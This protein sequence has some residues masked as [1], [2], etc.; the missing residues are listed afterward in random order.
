MV[1]MS[2]QSHDPS[3]EFSTTRQRL[4]ELIERESELDESERLPGL[5]AIASGLEQLVEAI[6]EEIVPVVELLQI[7]ERVTQ[8]PKNETV[9]KPPYSR[10]APRHPLGDPQGKMLHKTRQATR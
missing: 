3:I 8:V 6:I 10:W 4:T 7:Q 5:D 2:T 9:E 1:D